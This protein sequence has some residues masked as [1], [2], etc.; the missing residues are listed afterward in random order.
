[1]VKFDFVTEKTS[2]REKE[3]WRCASMECGVLYVQMDG[4]KLLLISS[5]LSL[6]TALEITV[7]FVIDHQLHIF[8]CFYFLSLSIKGISTGNYPPLFNNIVCSEPENYSM[9]LQCIDVHN[10]SINDDCENGTAEVICDIPNASSENMESI[11]NSM[12]T[13]VSII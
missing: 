10:F 9:L 2:I 13:S 7:G 12:S 11:S 3:E 1:M 5:A 4:M 8:T 6:D